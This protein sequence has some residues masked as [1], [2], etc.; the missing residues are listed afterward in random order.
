ML[1]RIR[2]FGGP[3]PESHDTT[4]INGG[5]NDEHHPEPAVASRPDD[6]ASHSGHLVADHHRKAPVARGQGALTLAVAI[7]GAAGAFARWVL[8]SIF[9]TAPGGFPAATFGINVGGCLLMGVLVVLVTEAR[10]AHPV[11]RPF[12]GVGVLGGFTTFSSYAVEAH[13]MVTGH[14]LGV[15]ALYLIATVVAA[16]LAVL[17]GLATARRLAGLTGPRR[18]RS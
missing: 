11:V 2:S 4:P 12:L 14:H 9:P 15:A 10:Q 7:G 8:Q 17:L 6:G 13:Q 1:R 18:T 5:A 16:L 3:L